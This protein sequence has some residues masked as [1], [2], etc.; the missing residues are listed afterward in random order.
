[1]SDQPTP[2]ET[3]WSTVV[4]RSEKARVPRPI[5]KYE[6]PG[7]SISQQVDIVFEDPEI[8]A[9]LRTQRAL[10]IVQTALQPGSVIF[11]LP[12]SAFNK[13]T[14]A[15]QMVVSQLGPVVGNSFVPI[16]VRGFS[17][18]GA[19]DLVFST[20]FCDPANT[21]KAINT[22]MVIN[23]V[24]YKATPYKDKTIANDYLRVYLTL[25]RHEDQLQD[26][27][28]KLKSSMSLYGKVLQIKRLLRDNFFEGEV[29]VVLN[30]KSEDGVD[31]KPLQRML[32]L[33]EWDVLVPARYTGADKVCYF[34]RKSGHIRQDC[35]VLKE[36]SCRRCH[37]KGHTQR[38]CTTDL[39]ERMYDSPVEDVSFEDAYNSYV[40]KSKQTE[41]N[42]HENTVGTQSDTGS[43]TPVKEKMGNTIENSTPLH[44]PAK[45]S[46]VEYI[47]AKASSTQRSKYAPYQKKPRLAT[48]KAK[49]MN[50]ISTRSTTSNIASEEHLSDSTLSDDEEMEMDFDEQTAAAIEEAA[51]TLPPIESARLGHE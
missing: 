37:Q 3:D 13:H 5:R 23:G 50:S 48:A 49:G 4:S 43:D 8:T 40:E 10:S 22:G 36:I 33:E 44:T 47:P 31:F 29:S 41:G 45:Q 11:S 21:S 14:D 28:E 34:C 6:K 20:V 46:S 15:Y 18:R 2:K 32:F 19:S 1:M 24:N 35:P 17:A 25:N 27:V 39:E 42:L 38:R 9:Y 51:N 16:S 30:R 12:Y 7:H 26:M